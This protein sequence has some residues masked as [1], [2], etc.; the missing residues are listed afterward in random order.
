MCMVLLSLRTSTQLTS[1][2]NK[3][4][5]HTYITSVHSTS[6]HFISLHLFT[7]SPHFNSLACNYILNP[8]STFLTFFT[9]RLEFVHRLR[10]SD[11]SKQ[12]MHQI[13]MFTCI[14]MANLITARRHISAIRNGVKFTSDVIEQ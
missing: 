9:E 8:L 5:S 4:T 6:L 11:L 2:Q 1:L 13:E 3:I 12:K 10:V 14:G 7:L